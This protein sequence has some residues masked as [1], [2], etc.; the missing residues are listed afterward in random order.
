MNQDFGALS[1]L[2]PLLAI[3]LAIWTKQVYLALMTGVWLG[4]TILNGWNPLI[5]LIDAVEALAD[6]FQDGERT[7]IV[8]VS[9]MIGALL[10]FVQF[11]GGMQGF[12]S[13]VSGRGHVATRRSAGGLA[14]ALGFF[15]FVESVIGV[16]VSGTI[17]RPLFDKLKGSREKL[18]YVLDSTCAPKAILLP[19]NTWGAYVIGILAAQNVES[20]VG[21]LIASVP[22]NL[23][24][25]LAVAGA[26]FVVL[27]DWNIGPMKTAEARVRNEGKLLR[28]GAE[29]LVAA[30]ALMLEPKEG[31]PPRT[32][33]MVLPVAAVIVSVPVLLYVTGDGNLMEGSGTNSA[34]YGILIGL[35]VGGIT[36][37]VQGVLTLNEIVDMFMKGVGALIPVGVLLVLAFAIGD[38]CRDLG[39][40][41]Y[42][43]G[44]AEQGFPPVLVPAA[45]FLLSGFIAFATGTSFGTWAIMIPIAVPMAMGLDL[46]LTLLVAAVLGGG[47][48]GDHCSPISDSTIV[49]SMAACTDHIDHVRTQIPYALVVAAITVV[50]YLLLGAVLR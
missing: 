39:T 14:W 19:L 4:W 9:I 42:V 46:N 8:M 48:F 5:G 11:S 35:L 27:T 20:P 1:L 31:A 29:P 24:S 16:L 28:D 2:P 18:A 7:R 49:S 38:V 25:I 22:L 43:A 15:I 45:L 26:L 3:G 10:T 40:G 17:T 12:I 32:I 23:Y 30:D 37:R 36:Y 41:T 50:L 33:N 44:V 21:T 34:F 6:I 47:I 13:W